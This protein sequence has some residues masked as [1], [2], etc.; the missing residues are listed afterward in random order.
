M[1]KFLSCF[2]I[3]LFLSACKPSDSKSISEGNDH[4]KRWVCINVLSPKLILCKLD[5][6][7]VT[8]ELNNIIIPGFFNKNEKKYFENLIHLSDSNIK[9]FANNAF[10]FSSNLMFNMS[11]SL[12]PEPK[13]S[14]CFARVTVIPG[15]DAEARLLNEGLA[16]LKNDLKPEVKDKYLPF[17]QNAEDYEKGIWAINHNKTND[18]AIDLS[19]SLLPVH[20]S[21]K[22]F[23]NKKFPKFHSADLYLI[24]KFKILDNETP[25]EISNAEMKLKVVAK[26]VSEQEG[27]LTLKIRPRVI[28][29][30]YSGPLS[31]F[32]KEVYD[33]RKISDLVYKGEN[34]SLC[35]EY[36]PIE[37]NRVIRGNNVSVFSGAIVEGCDIEIL[38]NNKLIYK[39]EKNIAREITINALNN[40]SENEF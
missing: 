27:E 1:N 18:L 17:Q 10:D 22:T 5:N 35:K 23:S 37:I 11:V 15:G 7:I 21:H 13:K 40:V 36:Q 39:T 9:T 2:I 33:W 38:M 12:S 6:N 20:E 34:V 28:E 26:L 16:V 25:E 19:V 8:V 31:A 14:Y 3:V 29:K 32:K 4:I 30:E 24:P